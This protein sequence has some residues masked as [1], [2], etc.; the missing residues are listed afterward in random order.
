M[1]KV[2]LFGRLSQEV[3][4]AGSAKMPVIHTSLAVDRITGKDK[5][6]ET[7]YFRLTAFSGTAKTMAEYLKVGDQILVEG[8]LTTGQYDKDGQ[9]HY[10]T[11]VIVDR[12]E[13]GAKSQKNAD[14][15]KKTSEAPSKKEEVVDLPESSDEDLDW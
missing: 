9:T 10:T 8:H 14:G 3:K 7:D 15:S 6:N 4:K 11:D 12:F 2:L 5:E 13:F 1:N